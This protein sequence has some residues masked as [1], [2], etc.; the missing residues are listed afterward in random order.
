MPMYTQANRPIKVITP[1]GQD[2]LLLQAFQTHE[3]LSEL[4]SFRLEMLAMHRSP[5]AF[6]R[7]IGQNVTVE[8]DLP[9]RGHRHFNGVVKQFTQ[10]GR[11]E[12][13]THYQAEVVPQF[14]LCTRKAQSRIFQ[15]LTVP[16]I[17]K[18]VLDGLT[19]AYRIIGNYHPRDYC[20]QYRES[21]FAFASR[22]MEEEGIYYWFEHTAD[23]HRMVLSDSPLT[24]PDLAPPKELI[25]Q[26]TLGGLVDEG[27]V[28]QWDKTQELRSG[29]CTLRDHCFE[30]PGHD[31]DAQQRTLPAVKVGQ[32]DHKLKVG[33]NDRLELYDYPGGYARRFDGVSPG[34]ADQPDKLQPI[35]G[36][37]H[38]TVKIRMEQET[39][40]SLEIAG[41]SDYAHLLPGHRFKL[42][43]HWDADGPY[44]L[45]GVEHTVRYTGDYRSGPDTAF[46]YANRFTAIPDALPYRP[47]QVTPKPVIPGMQTAVVVGPAGEAL[48]C[49][50]YGRVKVQFFWDRQGKKNEKSSCWIRVGQMNAGKGFG[51]LD[52]PRIGHEVIVA[53][54]EGDPDQPI[55]VGVVYNADNMPPYK[56]PDKRTYSGVIHRSHQGV[57][58]NAS[59]IR[60][61]NQLGSELLLVH[62]ETDALQQTEN[63]HLMQV[64]KFHRHEVGEFYHVV[65]GKPVNVNRSVVGY[66][67]ATAGS[68]AGG[69][70]PLPE[71]APDGQFL[72]DSLPGA[73]GSGAGGTGQGHGSSKS[74]T[75]DAG[76]SAPPAFNLPDGT[77]DQPFDPPG[78]QTDVHGH[79]ATNIDGDDTYSCGGTARADIKLD[80]HTEVG[81]IDYYRASNQ[82]GVVLL[83]AWNAVLGASLSFETSLLDIVATDK[84]E[85]SGLIHVDLAILKADGENIHNTK[86]TLKL[87]TLG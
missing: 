16:D 14:W 32:V 87:M 36:D 33:G 69:G 61:Q 1:L 21:D 53:F 71:D 44:L 48:H 4:F 5:V 67:V 79:N 27:R 3:G 20:V 11:D 17:L 46:E 10:S 24:H 25:F 13:F 51:S 60:F 42:T 7:L 81:G 76:A 15:N 6:D 12:T 29:R 18:Q 55:I 85:F 77:L 34:G 84:L 50:K 66:S 72:D 75:S 70:S 22:L 74:G 68:G 63:N 45:T 56:L 58:K 52:L 9:D 19:V 54:L 26:E 86:A 82:A 37:N 73:T 47:P 23:N 35:F 59:E 30:L 2:V 80:N 31:L 8:L 65:V 49:D 43:G 28:T 83:T 78:L 64:G 40:P 38:R 62:A 41:R 57:S 39:R